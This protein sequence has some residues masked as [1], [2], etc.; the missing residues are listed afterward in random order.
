[1]AKQGS[2]KSKKNNT[3]S[4]NSILLNN[5]DI[6]PKCSNSVLDNDKINEKGIIC[7]ACQQWW[8][9]R[10]ANVTNKEYELFGKNPNFKWFCSSC[11]DKPTK[12]NIE[13]NNVNQQITNM[14]TTM[15]SLLERMSK[16]EENQSKKQ[17]GNQSKCK[18]EENQLEDLV[19]V[20]VQEMTSESQEKEKRKL[21]LIAVNLPECPGSTREET[22]KNEIDQLSKMI[23]NILPD[24]NSQLQVTNPI[25]LGQKNIG[26]KPR[27]LKFKV[28]SVETKSKIL[29]NYHKINK[30]DTPAKDKVYINPDYT[31]KERDLNKALRNEL[32]ERLSNGE[33]NLMIKNWKIVNKPMPKTDENP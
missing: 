22:E 28:N 18:S 12:T 14:M 1:M 5:S 13:N 6:C 11:V 31:T 2:K 24:T 20:K 27:I 32:K 15:T 17:E 30:T 26:N 23:Q 21:N 33:T 25:R 19:E 16:L 10:C 9:I 4:N 29:K 8:H 3:S 7:E